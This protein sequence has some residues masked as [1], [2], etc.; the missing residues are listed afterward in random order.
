E[1]QNRELFAKIAAQPPKPGM[2]AAWEKLK[3]Q[4][5][6]RQARSNT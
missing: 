3:A 4:K 5:A 2:E 6:K 1:E